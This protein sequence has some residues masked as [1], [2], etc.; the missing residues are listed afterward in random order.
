VRGLPLTPAG[1]N[2]EGAS[3]R[4]QP[5]ASAR[6]A[7]PEVRRVSTASGA[8]TTIRQFIRVIRFYFKEWPVT[9]L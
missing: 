7:E 3:L 5:L 2:P 6:R 8:A 4:G 1:G 9:I